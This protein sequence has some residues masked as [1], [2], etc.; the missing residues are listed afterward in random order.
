[1]LEQ[2]SIC[3]DFYAAKDFEAFLENSQALV[4]ISEALLKCCLAYT[5][6][7]VPVLATVNDRKSV[8]QT[9][10]EQE[11]NFF[12]GYMDVEKFYDLTESYKNG[13]M[14]IRSKKLKPTLL[15]NETYHR[16]SF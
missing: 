9:I 3:L 10:L 6:H 2:L 5:H 16:G 4:E 15:Q 8:A 1:M 13:K 12:L 14:T 7:F 11:A